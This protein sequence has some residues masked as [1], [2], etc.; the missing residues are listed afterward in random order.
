MPMEE[1]ESIPLLTINSDL[2]TVMYNIVA[3]RDAFYDTDFYGFS[4]FL[5]SNYRFH[6]SGGVVHVPR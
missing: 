3:W 2:A 4:Y 6:A 1:E 5:Q